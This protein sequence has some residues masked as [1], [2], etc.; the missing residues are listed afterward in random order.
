MKRET[1][2]EIDLL[3]RRMSRRDGNSASEPQSNGE[4]LDADELS[5]YAQNALPA[6]ARTRYTEHL[7]DCSACRKMVTELSQSLG[8]TAAAT[9][10]TTIPAPSGLKKF[11]ASLFSPMVLRYAVP[12][13]GVLVVMVIG[14]VVLRQQ[15]RLAPY[16]AQLRQPQP[17]VGEKP[18]AL[19]EATPSGS[20][21]SVA[22]PFKEPQEPARE[23]SADAKLASVAKAEN[24]EGAAAAAPSATPAAVK[25]QRTDAPVVAEKHAEAPSVAAAPAAGAKVGTES[26]AQKKAD[27]VARKQPET[28]TVTNAANEEIAK[29]KANEPASRDS[30]GIAGAPSA[31]RVAAP[32][33]TRNKVG[34]GSAQGAADSIS[35]RR[36]EEDRDETETRSV[37]GRRFRK[38]RGIWI[39]TAYDS[40]KEPVSVA[41][42]SEQFRALVADEPGIKTIADQLDGE[43]IVVW[44]GRAYRIR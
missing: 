16:E 1:N 2:N 20:A 8:V 44:K 24:K 7:A 10:I 31:K 19:P 12:A 38:Q 18:V 29:A 42:G 15:Q 40:S 33:T 3:L 17:S 9:E 34:T 13:L 14:F 25:D 6:A 23:P 36:A 37:M 26:E 30:F 41:R 32:R 4:H 39:D 11:L 27:D 28:V 21:G 5:S 35:Q 43:I 22:K